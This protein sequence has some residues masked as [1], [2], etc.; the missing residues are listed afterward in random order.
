MGG[1]PHH[2]YWRAKLLY[3]R[4]L[5]KAARQ[6]V[7]G[8]VR[9]GTSTPVGGWGELSSP[10]TSASDVRQGLHGHDPDSPAARIVRAPQR[11]PV[12][13]RNRMILKPTGRGSPGTEP[14]HLQK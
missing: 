3:S 2:S 9:G 7:I 5:M 1:S 8:G 4:Q 12:Q 6:T 14:R 11:V 10:A 13:N